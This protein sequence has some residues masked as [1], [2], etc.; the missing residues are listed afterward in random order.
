MESKITQQALTVEEVLPRDT[1]GHFADG[2]LK[3][4]WTRA[5]PDRYL[6]WE[7]MVTVLL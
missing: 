2:L 6:F 3:M 1:A 5:L 4:R 7:R